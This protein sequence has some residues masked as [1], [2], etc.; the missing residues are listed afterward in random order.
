MCLCVCMCTCAR[1]HT[2][3]IEESCWVTQR[4]WVLIISAISNPLEVFKQQ[5]TEV[6]IS[7]EEDSSAYSVE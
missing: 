5:S 7:L 4:A 3:E 1:I 6:R 2:R